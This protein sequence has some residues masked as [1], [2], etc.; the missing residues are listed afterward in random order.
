MSEVFSNRIFPSMANGFPSEWVETLKRAE[1][2][3][4]AIFVPAHGFVG[5]AAIL[6]EAARRDYRLALEQVIAEGRR[7][8]DA[9]VPVDEAPDQRGLRA[10]RQLD[11]SRGERARRA[12][13]RLHGARWRAEANSYG[14]GGTGS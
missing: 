12:E 9:K 1:Q 10:L 8:H 3:D 5:S 13:A 14:C 2:I 7:L 6:A 4:A 11:A